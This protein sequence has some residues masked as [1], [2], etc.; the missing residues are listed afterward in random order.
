LITDKHSSQA[1]W[2]AQRKEF[3][4]FLGQR[5]VKEVLLLFNKFSLNK[6]EMV[7]DHFIFVP[8]HYSPLRDLYRKRFFCAATTWLK[9][10][11]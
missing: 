3:F 11:N 9:K 5:F 1:V 7:P 8:F 4:F 2:T 6:N 10:V